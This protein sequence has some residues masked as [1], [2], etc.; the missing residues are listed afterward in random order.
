VDDEQ[1]IDKEQ[2]AAKGHGDD[3]ICL[4]TD[5]YFPKGDDVE[6]QAGRDLIRLIHAY[7]PRIPVIIASKADIADDL[8][9]IAFILPKGDP[10]SLELLD[11]YIH[12]YTGI[13]D[14]L[15]S[16]PGRDEYRIKNIH[17]LYK[18]IK[19]A[20]KDTEE[21]L[22]LRKTLEGYGRKDS[23]STWLYMHGFRDLGDLL[24]PRRD[25]G[26]RMVTVLKRH[27]K[28]EMLRMEYTPLII[29]DKSVHTLR[30][31]YEVLQKIDPDSIQHLSD[32]DVFSMW[33]DRK[34]YSKLAEELRPIHARGKELISELT[35]VIKHWIAIYEEDTGSD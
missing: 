14:F 34:G 30:D 6:A 20:E 22:V 18:L 21:S 31:L 29:D 9:K 2:F 5:I 17:G 10:G 15:I 4:I 3:V 13:G 35:S 25:V 19:E 8:K 32:N 1:F 24:R 33:L 11:Q 12:D 7:Y 23:F 27:I 26:R 28:K 16:V